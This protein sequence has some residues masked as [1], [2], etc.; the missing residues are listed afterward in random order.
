VRFEV[1]DTG[2]GMAEEQQARLFRP[3][4]Q[5]DASTTR[6]YGGTGLGLAISKQLV[7]IMGGELGVESEPGVGS[8]FSFTLPLAK[9]EGES[10]AA[11]S[12]KS[13]APN[14]KVA[15]QQ[16]SGA[17]KA[18]RAGARVLVAEDTPTN[19]LVATELLKRRGFDADLVSTG[20]EAVEA[21]SRNAYAAVLMDIQMPGMDGYEATAEI[22]RREGAGRRT[23]IIAM[24]A[25]ALQGDREK[26]L[27]AGMDDYLSKPVRPEQLDR[28]LERWVTQASG[29][30]E[31]PFR[32]TDDASDPDGS[33]DAT[34]L[35][36]LRL[37]QREGGG[38]IVD[39]LVG[40]FL[41][42]APSHLAALRAERDNPR[43]FWQTAHSLNGACRSVGAAR[44]GKICLALERLGDSGDL[45]HASGLIAQL[46]EEFDHVKALLDAELSS[47]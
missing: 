46:E 9:R 36:D 6:R 15:R 32:T 40:A 39:R 23:P 8:T 41:E 33:L 7:E 10:H 17:P 21:L 31:A 28:V 27:A 34:V 2:I 47:S 30:Q 25:H 14:R 3:F 38:D 11:P 18:H 13:A 44:M 16:D 37:M 22:R 5:A 42:G 4:S 35:R 26:A 24:T 12:A 19:R 1:A 45:T 43:A 20:A 29:P